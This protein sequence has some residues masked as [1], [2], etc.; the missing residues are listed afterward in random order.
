MPLVQFLEG[1]QI[2]GGNQYQTLSDLIFAAANA[3]IDFAIGCSSIST[4]VFVDCR[5]IRRAQLLSDALRELG[6]ITSFAKPDW[7]QGLSLLSSVPQPL[8][9]QTFSSPS[10]CWPDPRSSQLLRVVADGQDF[11]S[12]GAG[13][14]LLWPPPGDGLILLRSPARCRRKSFQRAVAFGGRRIDRPK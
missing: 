6:S 4:E 13:F 14:L 10:A 12:P 3:D 9:W 11:Y 2:N 8:M 5:K 1:S 7:K